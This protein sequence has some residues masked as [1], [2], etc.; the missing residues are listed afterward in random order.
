M[1]DLA[2]NINS[3]RK[4]LMTLVGLCMV[5]FI[6]FSPVHA[7]FEYKPIVAEVPFSCI[8]AE[9]SEGVSYEFVMEPLDS[10]SPAP[11][12]K[13]IV[14]DGSGTKSFFIDITEPG[15]YQYK[16][17][18]IPGD[19]D[20]VI[21][22]ETVYQVTLFVTN[23]DANELEYKVVLALE[24]MVKPT[25]VKFLNAA[26]KQPPTPIVKTGDRLDPI[27]MIAVGFLIAGA[28]LLLTPRL[29]RKEADYE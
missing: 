5:L 29:R 10:K 13:S 19:N 14:I 16:L 7:A 18:E 12:Q 4:A 28:S 15:T 27:V 25:E 3:C 21:Y 20:K 17:Y 6:Y 8:G 9:I 1:R 22:D 2:K 23:N 24:G 11:R 26:V